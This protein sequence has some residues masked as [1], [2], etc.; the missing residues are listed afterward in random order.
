MRL[1][2]CF[3]NVNNFR[4]EV[5]SDAMSSAVADSTGAKVPVELADSRLS[6]SRDTRL[7]HFVTNDDE[8]TTRTTTTPA[9]GPYDSSSRY[10]AFCLKEE[11]SNGIFWVQI[12]EMIQI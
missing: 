9:D 1:F 3:S 11:A 8:A 7:P 2:G 4:P 10:A 6:R 5:C 12:L